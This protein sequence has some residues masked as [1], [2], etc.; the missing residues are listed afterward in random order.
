MALPMLSAAMTGKPELNEWISLSF[1][2]IVGAS[3]LFC[4]VVRGHVS[5]S[6]KFLAVFI[7]L[8]DL[9]AFCW[10]IQNRA[11]EQKVGRDHL[12]N[13]M[14]CKELA[15]YLQSRKGLFRVNFESDYSPNLGDMYGV[16]IIQSRMATELKDLRDFRGSAPRSLD[17]L[18]VR[19]LVS[20]KPLE[21]RTPVYADRFWLAYE[22]PDYLPRAWLVHKTAVVLRPDLA[23]P[24]MREPDFDPRHLA[25]LDHTLP[26]ELQENSEGKPEEVEVV[27]FEVD[28]LEIKVNAASRAMMVLS[29]VDYPGWKAEVNGSSVPIHKVNGLLKGIVVPAGISRV[30]L[31][32]KPTSVILGAIL[33]LAGF[34][35]CGSLAAWKRR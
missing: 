33:T 15:G 6:T 29:E 30:E 11:Q 21:G 16:Q 18:N 20:A 32:Y 19:Y 14:N 13:L 24:R 27:N 25:V 23:I 26:A 2:V 5:R 4:Y 3:A 9:S 31:R 34:A 35:L 10:I 22:N 12:Q 28:R 1:L 8:F 7:I 17:Q